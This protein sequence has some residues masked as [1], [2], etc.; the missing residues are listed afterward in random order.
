MEQL[1]TKEIH[2]LAMQEV[3]N[4]LKTQGYEFLGVNSDMK[5]SPQFVC[6]KKKLLYFIVVSGCLYPNSP[7]KYDLKSMEKV[8]IHAKKNRAKLYFAGVGFA[9]SEN[10]NLP[11][12]KNKSYVVNFSGLEK[13]L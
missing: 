12:L 2:Q 1:N 5:Q 11:L 6:V 8:I 9:N 3:G 13:I 10:Y 4:F 7:K